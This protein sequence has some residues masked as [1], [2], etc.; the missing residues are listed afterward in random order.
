M[1]K[2]EKNIIYIL[3]GILIIMV[4]C[5]VFVVVN[6]NFR[7][8]FSKEDKRDREFTKVEN[9]IKN[10]EINIVSNSGNII[11]NI[12]LPKDFQYTKDDINIGEILKEKS[13]FS[14]KSGYNFDDDLGKKVDIIYYKLE[15]NSNYL[16]ALLDD[17]N[18]LG[19]WIDKADKIK[20]AT[21]QF[22][23]VMKTMAT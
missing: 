22:L 19:L 18:I 1:E 8:Y 21:D 17:K 23:S 10:H 16:I 4:F 6:Y 5:I 12:T 15:G 13:E 14:K 20:I 11:E 2:K 3:T 7:E 9:Y